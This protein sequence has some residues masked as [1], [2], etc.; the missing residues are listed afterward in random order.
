MNRKDLF[1]FNSVKS[2]QLL[3]SFRPSSTPLNDFASPGL[4]NINI[5]SFL[6]KSCES[7][8][9]VV[10]KK[11]TLEENKKTEFVQEGKGFVEE[12]H[13]KIF[14][15]PILIKR[16]LLEG[17]EKKESFEEP[18]TEQTGSNKSK[19]GKKELP[20]KKKS[21]FMFKVVD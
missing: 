17:E 19:L 20:S 18:K 9:N 13:E 14:E 15:K 21:K 12:E 10:Y 3:K 2:V 7:P 5:H 8:S 16:T 1:L 4:S 11:E 6:V